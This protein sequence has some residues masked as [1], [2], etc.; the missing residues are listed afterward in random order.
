MNRHFT[1]AL[2][3]LGITAATLIPWSKPTAPGSNTYAYGFPLAFVH[4]TNAH[5]HGP[6]ERVRIASPWDH[7][8]KVHRGNFLVDLLL[9]CGLVWLVRRPTKRTR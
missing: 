6:T 5:E 4:Q 2:L 1:T 9:I 3:A 8:T 7:P